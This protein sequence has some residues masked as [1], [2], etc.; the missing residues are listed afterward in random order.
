MAFNKSHKV[1]VLEIPE[2][3][4]NGSGDRS[5]EE[6]SHVRVNAFQPNVRNFCRVIGGIQMKNQESNNQAFVFGDRFPNEV[7]FPLGDPGQGRVCEQIRPNV[8]MTAREFDE[9]RDLARPEI[10]EETEAREKQPITD[11]AN[12]IVTMFRRTVEDSQLNG[13]ASCILEH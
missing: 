9:R 13:L 4:P 8:P 6:L 3:G 7:H 11:R 1:P 2:L 10:V 12:R 5:G